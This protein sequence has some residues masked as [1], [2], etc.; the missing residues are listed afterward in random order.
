MYGTPQLPAYFTSFNDPNIGANVNPINSTPVP[1]DWGGIEIRND[2]DRSQGRSD[3]ELRG[4]FRNYIN[5]AAILFGGGGVTTLGRSVD[6]IQLSE[7]RAEIS[8]NLIQDSANA[9]ISADPGT[10]ET[11]TFASPRFQRNNIGGVGF[12]P[13]YDRIGPSI[14]GNMLI[15]NSTNGVFVRIDTLPGN[16]LEKLQVPARFNDTDIVHVFGETFIVGGKPGGP[17]FQSTPATPFAG[18]QAT[19]VAT[20]NIAPGN[21]SYAYTFIDANGYESLPSVPVNVA[22]GGGNNAVQF[23]S[24]PPATGEFVGRRLYR[25]DGGTGN[26][27]LVAQM[28]RSSN[29]FVD[30]VAAALP[31]AP[32]ADPTQTFLFRGRPDASL[33][34][35]PGTIIKSQGSR[36]ELDFNTTLIAEGVEGRE[37]IFTS[38]EDDRYGASG[39]FDT[40]DDGNPN[41]TAGQYQLANAQWAGIYANRFARLSLDHAF[42]AGAGGITGVEGT[43]AGFNAVEIHQA[44]ARIAHSVFENNADGQGGQA[45]NAR[46][47]RG[48]NSASTIHVTGAQ[49]VIIDN[50]FVDNEGAVISMNAGSLTADWVIDH[51]RQ[52]GPVDVF[53]APPANNGPLVRAN[54]LADNDINGLLIRGEEV[55]EETVW[56]DTDIVHVLRSNI[57]NDNWHVS[58]GIRLE[59]SASESLVVKLDRGASIDA[60]GTEFDIDDRIGGRVQVLGSPGFPVIMTALNDRTVGA[61]FTP[62]GVPQTDTLR[63]F[64][65]PSAGD[66]DGLGLL[67]NSNDRNVDTTTEREGEI[68]GFGDQNS[69]IGSHQDLGLLAPN[70]RSGD[71]NLRLGFTVHGAIADDGDQDI[72]SFA[73]TA[74][75]MVWIDIDNTQ[76]GLDTVLELLDGDGNILALSDGSREESTNGAL[77]YVNPVNPSIGDN[78]GFEDGKAL[79]MNLDIMAELN[80]RGGGFRDLYSVN[81]GDAGMRVVLPGNAGTTRTF[82]IRVRSNNGQDLSNPANLTTNLDGG[83]TN[84]GYQLQVRLREADEI[85]GSVI[86]YA[87]IRY[88]TTAIDVSGLPSHSPLTGELSANGATVSLGDIGATDRAAISVAGNASVNGTRY[89]F[90]VNRGGIQGLPA[91]PGEDDPDN[92][93]STVIDVDWADGLSRPNTNAYLYHTRGDITTLVAIGTDSNVLDDR[94]TPTAGGLDTTTDILDGSSFGTRDAFIGPIELSSIGSYSVI[95]TSNE[96]V[97]DELLQF[98]DPLIPLP[99][100]TPE[101]IERLDRIRQI[102]LEPLESTVRVSDDRFSIE[103]DEEP[104]TGNGVTQAPE[105]LQVAFEDDGSSIVPW[106]LGD[107]PLIALRED[108]TPQGGARLSVYNAMTGRHDSV[109]TRNTTERLATAAQRPDGY[110]IAIR[111][112]GNQNQTDATTSTTYTIDL[113]GNVTDLGAT[114]IQTYENFLNNTPA[115]VNRLDNEGMEF[116]SLAYINDDNSETSFLYGLANRGFFDGSTVINNMGT[117]A[118]GPGITDLDANNLIYLLD[119]NTGTAISRRTTNMTAGFESANPLDPLIQNNFNNFNWPPETPWAGT[120]IVAQVQVPV[121]SPNTNGFTGNVTSIAAA[122]DGSKT[123]YA[124]TERGAVWRMSI[125]E[126]AGGSYGAGDIVGAPQ[127]IVDPTTVGGIG[128]VDYI[129]DTQGNTIAFEYVTQGPTNFSNPNDDE[130]IS[131]LYFAVGYPAAAGGPATSAERRFYAVDLDDL[132][133]RPVFNYGGDSILVDESNTGGGEFGALFFS[134]LDR[135]LWH[136]SDTLDEQGQ[137]IAGH[138]FTQLDDQVRP[139]LDGGGALRFGFDEINGNDGDFNHLSTASLEPQN[140]LDADDMQGFMGYNFIG[141]AHGSI[142]SNPL[143]LRGISSEELPHL[144][145][146][147]QLDSEGRNTTGTAADL[148]TNPMRDSLRVYVGDQNGDWT[149]VATNNFD[150]SVINR[151]NPNN[152]F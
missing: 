147:Y 137:P 136:L 78:T 9:A 24:I 76:R 63:N 28:D 12:V 47:G 45:S 94:V 77:T 138:G 67:E 144:Y 57:R 142:Q 37:V 82:Y 31:T 20:G 108:S 65:L 86:R 124:F 93:I 38:R 146:T 119:P 96:S 150:D 134:P 97:P 79:P 105:V 128:G 34:I 26:F 127:L 14:Y 74:G 8:Y 140:G 122:T 39:T 95:V 70:E 56:D 126:N 36:I 141:G 130:G 35:D 11:S 100:D 89:D 99:G 43:T 18:L 29:N 151:N 3:D 98:S 15:G 101:E 16:E 64:G 40:N 54:R 73:G 10:F 66:W 51:G 106:N 60:T 44:D 7:A 91:G 23:F 107:I 2:V 135:N 102:R 55:Y 52:T 53:P 80:Q 46:E 88:A 103:T 50:V 131:E 117:D 1:G 49:P 33:V 123:L 132:T 4:I 72:Y 92:R 90:T 115:F 148:A 61:G 32:S 25:Q 69:I 125:T 145:F 116:E 133:A 139:Q 19:N 81:D 104:E 85:G 41:R 149:L 152:K 42:V 6:A 118:I 121:I 58:G 13:D 111:N 22:V 87:D 21:Y 59:S 75:S 30:T 68:G 5:H 110:I 120:Q 113:E 17:E 129:A 84:G 71:E 83:L 114:G 143:D 62:T 109:I 27:S 112:T 48:P